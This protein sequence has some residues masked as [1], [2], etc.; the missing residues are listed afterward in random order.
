MTGNVSLQS[1]AAH[2]LQKFQALKAHK[3]LFQHSVILCI[4]TSWCHIILTEHFS[5]RLQAYLWFLEFLKVDCEAEPSAV[6]PLV[7]RTS[8]DSGDRHTLLLG[9]GFKLSFLIKIF[10]LRRFNNGNCFMSQCCQVRLQSQRGKQWSE[11]A[12]WPKLLWPCAKN[13]WWTMSATTHS[14]PKQLNMA[15]VWVFVMFV[16]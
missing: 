10:F 16:W 13:L 12:A 11:T 3:R 9:L 6:G 1:T 5:L 7:C 14:Q 2:P 4:F 8:L 15:S